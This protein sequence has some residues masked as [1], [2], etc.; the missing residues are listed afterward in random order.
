MEKI[1]KE[2]GCSKSTVSRAISGKGRISAATKDKIF[3]YCELSGYETKLTEIQ[4]A[5]TYN[6]SVILPSNQEVSEIPFFHSCMMG[7]CEAAKKMGYNILIMSLEEGEINPLK[8]ILDQHKVDGVILLR[9]WVTDVRIEYLMSRYIP[10]IVIGHSQKY[11]AQYVDNDTV[12]ACKEF[13]SYLIEKK[14]YRM[15][16]I[17]GNMKH[18]VSQKRLEGFLEGFFLYN[19]EPMDNLLF[20]DCNTKEKVYEAAEKVLENNAECVVCMDSNICCQVLE[21]FQHLHVVVPKDIKVASFYDSYFLE[22]YAPP[23]TSLKFDET[24]LGML[25]CE[26]L[27]SRLEKKEYESKVFTG[28]EIVPRASTN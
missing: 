18:T 15:A 27:I 4:R 28:Y 23:I 22:H 24:K 7:I 6:L 2:L 16:L 9:A 14:L 26:K 12:R 21:K 13:T 8:K 19:R 17:G 5:R 25:A 20:L 1:A 11:S 10:F 3:K